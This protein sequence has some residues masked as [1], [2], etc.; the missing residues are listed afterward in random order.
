M[1]TSSA[2]ASAGDDLAP[3]GAFRFVFVFVCFRWVT[4]FSLRVG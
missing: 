4:K 2:G 1:L 3:F